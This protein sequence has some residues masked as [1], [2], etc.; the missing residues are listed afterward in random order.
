[1]DR[2]QREILKGKYLKEMDVLRKMYDEEA[3]SSAEF[4]SKYRALLNKVLEMDNENELDEHGM[5]TTD[6]FSNQP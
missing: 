6:L 4:R 5:T 3:M 2:A 1:M